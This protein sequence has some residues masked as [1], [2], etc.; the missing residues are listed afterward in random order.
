MVELS[1]LITILD[2]SIVEG[3]EVF[4]VVLEIPQGNSNGA[5]LGTQFRTNVTII[6]N[7]ATLLSHKLS[8]CND[9]TLQVVAGKSFSTSI[10]AMGNDG[11]PMTI[12]GGERFFAVIENN[13]RLW[14]HPGTASGSQR[15][16]LRQVCTVSG[17]NHSA[18]SYTV[19][20]TGIVEQGN[21][22]LR[23]YY[24]FPNAI[25][26]DYFYDGFFDRLAMSRFDH[27]VNY[28]W[29]TGRLIPSGTDYVTVRWSGAILS[30]STSGNYSF[31]VDADDHA[32]LWIDGRLLMDHWHMG[33][34][35]LLEVP[36][37][38]YLAANTL[39]EL[40][41]EYREVQDSA[42]ARLLWSLPGSATLQVVPQTSLYSLLEISQSP[43]I[44]TIQSAVT[45]ASTTECHGE[46]LYSGT[47]L[48]T[49]YFTICPRDVY[50]N[51]R[52]DDD[53]LFY[54]STDIFFANL[55]LINNHAH[56]GVGPE[57][58][59]PDIWFNPNT[60]CFDASY[61]PQR[62]GN[63][64]LSIFHE[65]SRGSQGNKAHVSGSPF[66][67]TVIPDTM[68]GPLSVIDNLV[69]QQPLYMVAGFCSN[70]TVVARDNAENLLL[71][72]GNHIQ[73]G[74]KTKWTHSIF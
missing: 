28:T 51:M 63:Y 42:H 48:H 52:D 74:G 56:Q 70:F 32:R 40:V 18:S 3:D 71:K 19:S 72:G 14:I 45:A 6:D 20:S 62:S 39:Y 64:E 2:D 37:V 57:T 24:A 36:K 49:S 34:V 50:G 31:K 33:D 8:R 9:T 38:I 66:Y 30:G 15:N 12:V 11:Q 22:Q 55:T 53:D 59:V 69:S 68:S 73:V 21:Y 65:A 43:V 60:Y 13:E 23:V 17:S 4:Q 25:R 41:L 46:G 67:L 44:I 29:G 27:N 7:D 16:A 54:L 58:I 35:N 61:T 47:A 26:G 5:S 1:F 10:L